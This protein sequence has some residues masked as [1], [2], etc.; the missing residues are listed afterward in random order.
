M[1]KVINIIS[2]ISITI[3]GFYMNVKDIVEND[4]YKEWF[5]NTRNNILKIY[6]FIKYITL[7]LYNQENVKCYSNDNLIVFVKDNSVICFD[8][9][10]F[11]S[12]KKLLDLNNDKTITEHPIINCYIFKY[13]S[14]FLEDEKYL[15]VLLRNGVHKRIDKYKLRNISLDDIILD[16]INVNENLTRIKELVKLMDV[17]ENYYTITFY[18]GEKYLITINPKY[19][20]FMGH[21]SNM[22]LTDVSEAIKNK[23][24]SVYNF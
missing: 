24:E 22:P 1:L 10:T 16:S 13:P 15:Y 9:L 19:G 5:L 2:T 4:K 23:H 20:I 17:N 6:V 8:L 21:K 14:I 18:D 3:I 7:L 12:T 11:R